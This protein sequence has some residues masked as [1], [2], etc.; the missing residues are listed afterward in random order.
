MLEVGA[1]APDFTLEAHTGEQVTLSQLRGQIVV[2]FFYPKDNT[3]GCTKESCSFRDLKSEFSQA[4]A[5]VYGIS[6]DSLDS[7]NKF[8]DKFQLNMPLLSDANEEVCKLY[9]VLKEKNMYGRKSI[10]IER[11]TFVIAADG[12]V[13]KIYPKVKVDGH[14]EKVLEF[15]KTMGV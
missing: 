10:G 1:A 4:G 2:L 6:R 7:H 9:G 13:A 5:L 11:T 3:P 12:T 8:V 15:V 14:A